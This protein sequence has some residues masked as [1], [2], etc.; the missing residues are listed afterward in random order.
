[1]ASIDNAIENSE[2]TRTWATNRSTIPS[3]IVPFVLPS[4]LPWYTVQ[5]VS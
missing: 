1:M 3:F 2:D 4:C 5:V